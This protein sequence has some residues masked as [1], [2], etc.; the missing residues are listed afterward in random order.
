ME[1]TVSVSGSEG[2]LA[3]EGHCVSTDHDCGG[4]GV[5]KLEASSL[6]R[7]TLLFTV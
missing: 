4:R 6:L 2:I 7:S 1:M 5:R 3:P